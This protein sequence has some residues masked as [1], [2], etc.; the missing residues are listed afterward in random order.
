MNV[1]LDW[2]REI[3]FLFFAC[4]TNAAT[5]LDSTKH[6]VIDLVTGNTLLVENRWGSSF[7]YFD[8]SGLFQATGADGVIRSEGTWRATED[9]VCSIV[10]KPNH[11]GKGAEFCMYIFGRK[12]GE[13]WNGDD[14]KNGEIVFKLFLGKKRP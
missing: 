13:S 4:A 6:G 7:I 11:G 12:I 10:N 9:S 5:A 8:S 3:L 2:R 1:T 14:P